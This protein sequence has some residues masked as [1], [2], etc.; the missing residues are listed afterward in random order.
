MKKIYPLLLLFF[1]VQLFAQESDCKYSEVKLGSK[2]HIAELR[3]E[4]TMVENFQTEQKGRIVDFSLFNTK[5]LVIL[6]VEIYKDAKEKLL[7]VCIGKGAELELSLSNGDKIIL[8]QIGAK[9]CGYEIPSSE[10]GFV[11]VKNMASFLIAEDKFENL[12]NHEVLF[13]N[14]SSKELNFSFIMKSS[15]Y[16]EQTNQELYPSRFFIN[17]LDCV[18]NPKIIVQD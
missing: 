15:L 10:K 4:P 14:F 3:T 2:K 16:N 7:P 1:M 17:Q 11:N 13:I 6:N 12:K 18:V 9:L 5:G 8:P